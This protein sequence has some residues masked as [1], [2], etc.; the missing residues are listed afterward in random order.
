MNFIN[1]NN[2]KE[3][4]NNNNYPLYDYK[5]DYSFKLN[6]SNS[7]EY[8]S[9]Q[10]SKFCT[11]QVL[12]G[13]KETNE[14]LNNN[15]TLKQ[16]EN[17]FNNNSIKKEENETKNNMQSIQLPPTIQ[18]ISGNNTIEE[19]KNMEVNKDY[20]NNNKKDILNQEK[21]DNY[22]EIL[23]S[24]FEYIKLITQR[25]ALNDIITYGDIKYKYKIGF[26]QLIIVIKSLPFNIIRAIQQSQYY[27]F[28]FRQLFIPY[29]SRAFHNIKIYSSYKIFFI[30]V[31]QILKYIYKKIIL[32]KI[33]N[34]NKN[35]KPY[36]EIKNSEENITIK[37]LEEISELKDLYCKNDIEEDISESKEMDSIEWEN[38]FI[39]NKQITN[40]DNSNIINNFAKIYQNEN[41]YSADFNI[42]IKEIVF[43][44]DNQG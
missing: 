15:N 12:I 21:L 7:N 26:S 28:A 10:T 17:L 22:K 1:I 38:D 40:R 18:L 16:D 37:N 13:E 33:K 6:D 23:S 2:I 25:N 3:E 36:N 4:D 11:S 14:P 5:N 35:M 27:H 41:S 39:N 30:K 42:N 9:Y 31:E 20:K 8:N 24:L 32:R 34:F 29:I 19:N 43:E 44:D